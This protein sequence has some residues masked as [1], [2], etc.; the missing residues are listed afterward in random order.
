M[1]ANIPPQEPPREP[2][3][4][5]TTELTGPHLE[6]MQEISTRLMDALPAGDD[7]WQVLAE[8]EAL[9]LEAQLQNVPP[10]GV[11]GQSGVA[12]F[13]QSIMDEFEA[14][15]RAS[16]G[17]PPGGRARPA[18]SPAATDPSVKGKRPPHKPRGEWGIRHRRRVTVALATVVCLLLAFAACLY[19]GLWGY[20]TKGTSFYLDEL[21]NFQSTVTETVVPPTHITLPMLQANALHQTL[22]DD[23]THTITLTALD[24]RDYTEIMDGENGKTT[25]EMRRWFLHMEYTVVSDFRTVT[26]V[27]PSA[28]GTAT[29]TLADGTAY[30]GNIQ[31]YSSGSSAKGEEFAEII[32]I[33]LPAA[34]DTAGATLTLELEPPCRVVWERFATGLR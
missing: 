10:R 17:V 12:G 20:W 24:C 13:C 21:Y 8:A 16:E 14:D 15:R 23:G 29:V 19:T 28:R 6:A 5:P 1:K 9:L 32:V 3:R 33:E 7:L 30:A 25:R 34:V 2:S 31:W 18:A 4:V 22:Y 27:E 26:Y 11:F